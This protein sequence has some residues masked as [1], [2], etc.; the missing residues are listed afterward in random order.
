[1]SS[2]IKCPI[3]RPGLIL[4]KSDGNWRATCPRC[5]A[6]VAIPEATAA[7]DAIQAETPERERAGQRPA[8][9][10]AGPWKPHG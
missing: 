10:A 4:P 9:T 1:M 3:C 8:R 2:R 7:P 6:E 5:L